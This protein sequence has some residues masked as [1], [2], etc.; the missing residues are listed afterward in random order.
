MKTIETKVMYRWKNESCEDFQS[1]KFYDGVVSNQALTVKADGG[2]WVEVNADEAKFFTPELV[3]KC[4]CDRCEGVGKP[5]F[6][7][8][9]NCWIC[10]GLGY[11]WK[12]AMAWVNVYTVSR[13]Y[14][15]PEEGGWWFDALE[16]IEGHPVLRCEAEELREELL[17]LH[18]DREWGNI[19]SVLG[20]EKLVVYVED[21]EAESETTERPVY[22]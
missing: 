6:D 22:C 12:P 19:S 1:N 7:G 15:G 11:W 10:E 17:E 21:Y 3:V 5:E 18:Q 20:G 2:E 16:F 13:C 14:G 9:M 4:E 8:G